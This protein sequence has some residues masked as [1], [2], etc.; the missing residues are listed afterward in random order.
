MGQSGL[1][2]FD[3]SVLLGCSVQGNLKT[4]FPDS[5]AENK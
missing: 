4:S 3:P 5:V 1:A 2:S